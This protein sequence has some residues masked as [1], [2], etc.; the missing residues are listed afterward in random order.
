MLALDK[1][2]RCDSLRLKFQSRYISNALAV[3]DLNRVGGGGGGEE[4][5]PVTVISSRD[6]LIASY[7]ES[8]IRRFRLDPLNEQ[9]VGERLTWTKMGRSSLRE[10]RQQDAP[11]FFPVSSAPRNERINRRGVELSSSAGASRENGSV[12]CSSREDV[13]YVSQFGE[14]PERYARI[15]LLLFLPW[16]K[17]VVHCTPFNGSCYVWWRR[18]ASKNSRR[19]PASR[20]AKPLVVTVSFSSAFFLCLP[21]LFISIGRCTLRGYSRFTY[22]KRMADERGLA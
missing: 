16:T 15:L 3:R 1:I 19:H 13:P 6:A 21:V 17:E 12:L 11:L 22:E 8:A 9:H 14:P 4:G 18:C 2:S 7:R 10:E 5:G 20:F